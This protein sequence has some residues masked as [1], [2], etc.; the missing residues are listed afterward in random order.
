MYD[1]HSE[2]AIRGIT[3]AGILSFAT[4]K[5]TRLDVGRSCCRVKNS[6]LQV[7][8]VEGKGG[9]VVATPACVLD[10]D[11]RNAKPGDGCGPD[12]RAREPF[13]SVQ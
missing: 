8:K 11:S 5:D 13:G 12:R 7:K 6:E 3:I 4:D 9:R 2:Q 1:L 10:W